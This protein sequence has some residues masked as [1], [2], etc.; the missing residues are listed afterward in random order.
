MLEQRQWQA[1]AMATAAGGAVNKSWKP[2]A[3]GCGCRH[4]CLFQHTLRY[5]PAAATAATAAMVHEFTRADDARTRLRQKKSLELL[6]TGQ[7]PTNSRDD[8]DDD[9][10][11]Q[12]VSIVFVFPER[13]SSDI[14]RCF[15]S[16]T[17]FRFPY[18]PHTTKIIYN[19]RSGPHKTTRYVPTRLLPDLKRDG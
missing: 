14:P 2:S 6:Y 3:G 18:R 8:D 16:S 4:R 7:T 11:F 5:Y 10:V 12:I 1:T 13:H 19:V 9:D 17:R 15:S